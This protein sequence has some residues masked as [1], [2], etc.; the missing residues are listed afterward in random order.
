MTPAGFRPFGGLRS[1]TLNP[2]IGA[3]FT[4]NTGSTIDSLAVAS[5]GEEWRLATAPAQSRSTSST[6]PWPPSS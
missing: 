5:T 3:C 4:N 1:G 2:I 6:A